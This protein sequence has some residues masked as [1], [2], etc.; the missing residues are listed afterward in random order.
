MKPMRACDVVTEKVRYPVSFPK[1]V[2][3]APRFP[4]FQS[5]RMAADLL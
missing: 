4:T 2:K 5:L 1:G 3:D